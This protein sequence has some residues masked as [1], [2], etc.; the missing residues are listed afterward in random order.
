MPFPITLSLPSSPNPAKP[1]LT[2]TSTPQEWIKHTVWKDACRSWYKDNATGRVNAVYPGSSLHYMKLLGIPRYEDFEISRFSAN[3]WEFLGLGW[4]MEE[5][6]GPQ[7][8]DVSPYLS[9]ANV[10]PKWYAACGGD[11]ERLKGLAREARERERE[12]EGEGIERR[13]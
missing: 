8:A 3:P 13:I 12:K 7:E 2:H 1:Q 9:L 5:R 11:V 10:D 6:L 4:T